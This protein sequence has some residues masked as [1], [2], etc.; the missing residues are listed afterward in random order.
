MAHH[1]RGHMAADR[2][3]LEAGTGGCPPKYICTMEAE[4]EQEIILSYKASG[5]TARTLLE[6]GSVS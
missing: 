5:S 2:E 1:G 3:S 6:P 4:G